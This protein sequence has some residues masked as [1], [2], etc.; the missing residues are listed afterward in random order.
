MKI[1]HLFFCF[2]SFSFLFSFGQEKNTSKK[3]LLNTYQP[4][5][6][7]G[8]DVLNAGIGFFS[9]RKLYQGFVSTELKPRLHAILDVGFE[10]NTYN[11]SGYHISANGSFVKLGTVYMLISDPENRFNGF[12]AGG[13][14]VGSI[15]SQEY[16]SVPVKGFQ[17]GDYSVA[18]PQTT[19]STY[20]VEGAVG[21]RIQLFS[22]PVYID[23]NIQP[24]YLVYT[25]KQDG[26]QPMIV[27]GFGESISSFGF[28]YS[29]S[30][31]YK[32]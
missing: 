27:P 28:G 10:K 23:A 4:N 1:K 5:F 2:F 24:K 16:F 21:A 13:K 22:S 15:Y 29:W 9:D 11:K 30:L 20:W 8:I 25:T 17:A 14:I 32:F 18:F 3:T 26:I 7:V 12:Y 31:A 6:M 19:Q